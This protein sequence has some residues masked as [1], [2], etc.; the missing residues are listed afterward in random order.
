MYCIV[1]YLFQFQ[2]AAYISNKLQLEWVKKTE[3]SKFWHDR[4]FE[5]PAHILWVNMI[6]CVD[7]ENGNNNNIFNDNADDINIDDANNI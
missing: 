5:F 4:I 1:F 7:D 2:L 6:R 3:V